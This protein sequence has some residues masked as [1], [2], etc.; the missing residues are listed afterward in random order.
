VIALYSTLQVYLIVRKYAFQLTYPPR[1][2]SNCVCIHI[3]PLD[4]ITNNTN[5]ICVSMQS[6]NLSAHINNEYEGGVCVRVALMK[7]LLRMYK[8]RKDKHAK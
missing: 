3:H 6:S 1:I 2:K 8:C 4:I 5:G 7:C